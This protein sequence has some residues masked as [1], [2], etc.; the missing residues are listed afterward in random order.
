[1]V[2]RQRRIIE[3]LDQVRHAKFNIIALSTLALFAYVS[4]PALAAL[5]RGLHLFALA[6]VHVYQLKLAHQW[7]H[8]EQQLAV[9][10]TTLRRGRNVS[11]N[12]TLQHS[13]MAHEDSDNTLV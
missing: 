6:A 2:R 8:K 10:L 12:H 4:S 3:P 11:S 13:G 1:M 7:T 9:L 5:C